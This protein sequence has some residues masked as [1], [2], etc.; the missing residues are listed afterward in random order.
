MSKIYPGMVHL[1]GNL[2][3][4]VD[5]ET[6][7]RRAGYHDLVQ[8]AV[9]PLNSDLRPLEGV[10]PF[11]TP[12]RPR[13]P[14]RVERKAVQVHGLDIDE[15]LI[16]APDPK[17]VQDLFVE[18]HSQLELPFG[19][20]LIP[21]A[22]N[23]AFEYGFTVA[24]LGIELTSELFYGHP[25]DSM[26]VAGYINDREAMLGNAPPFHM[27]GLKSMARK[28]GIINEKPH[29]AFHDAITEA[30]VYRTLVKMDK[31]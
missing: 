7:G 11:Y 28:F 18:W 2:I 26:L 20:K 3:A 12:M 6:L 5:Y 4:A 15:L 30:E 31:F 24:W 22:H 27:L 9:V 21:L 16:H 10:R 25:R 13:H 8:I 1:N 19:K 14:K 17:R 23:W 29:D